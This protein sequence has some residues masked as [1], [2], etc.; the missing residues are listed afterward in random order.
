MNST[1]AAIIQLADILIR[2]KGYH[3]FSYRDISV[4]LQI[5]NAA[6]HYHFPAKKDL[7]LAVIQRNRKSFVDQTQVWAS[8]SPGH[9]IKQFV[10]IY[11]TIQKSNLVCFMGALGPFFHQL[12]EEMQAAL[13]ETSHT[14]RQWVT[15]TLERGL[16]E[17]QFHFSQSPSDLADVL[18]S[19]LMASLIL[20]EV[21]HEDLTKKIENLVAYGTI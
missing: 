13:R 15:K 12:P 14:I 4:P 20:N 16:M 11:K 6:I 10:N 3:G 17:G 1:K 9:Q 7:G 5:K 18:V 21:T 2:Q 8:Q 19:A